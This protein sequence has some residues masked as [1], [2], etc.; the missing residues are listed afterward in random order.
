MPVPAPTPTPPAALMSPPTPTWPA[1]STLLALFRHSSLTLLSFSSDS[2][3]SSSTFLP[4]FLYSSSILLLFFFSSSMF[5]YYSSFSL[6]LF[7]AVLLHLLF[8]DYSIVP[9]LFLHYVPILLLFLFLRYSCTT[10]PL[11]FHYSSITLV[12]LV[13][14]RLF[15]SSTALLALF[16][17][18]HSC[19][20]LLSFR[21]ESS[22]HPQHWH[23]ASPT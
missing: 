23:P 16:L 12:L 2:L 13:Y 14:R 17:L 20:T 15:H 4:R 9:P 8:Y 11:L 5:F 7:S 10:L 22:H 3:S 1:P 18:Y 6:P 19:I 21:M